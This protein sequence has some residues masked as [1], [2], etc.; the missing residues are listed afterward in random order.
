MT[1]RQKKSGKFAPNRA[2]QPAF[3]HPFKRWN[4]LSKGENQTSRQQRRATA[5]KLAKQLA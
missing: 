1:N 3:V 4:L 2:E 5:R